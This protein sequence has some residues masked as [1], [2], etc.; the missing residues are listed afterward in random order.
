M[1]IY[2]RWDIILIPF[3]FTG[4]TNLKKRPALILSPDEYNRQAD[5]VIG[6]ITSKLDSNPRFGDY[7]IKNWKAS[8][9]PKP[10]IIRMKFATID[11]SIVLKKIGRL[12]GKDRISYQ[13]KLIEFFK[14]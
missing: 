8:G 7:R 12:N 5:L 13:K 3:S 9:L 11:K 10:S 14:S 2:K 6:F 4:L 1:T